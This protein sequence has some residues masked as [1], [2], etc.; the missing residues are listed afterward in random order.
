MNNPSPTLPEPIR[1][2]RVK[3][4]RI[5]WEASDLDLAEITAQRA[6][7]LAP[8]IATG[9]WFLNPQYTVSSAAPSPEFFRTVLN[10][11]ASW[12]RTCREVQ[13]TSGQR[14]LARQVINKGRLAATLT[15]D[16]VAGLDIPSHLSSRS[17]LVADLPDE[18]RRVAIEAGQIAK[19]LAYSGILFIDGNPVPPRTWQVMHEGLSTAH[20]RANDGAGSPDAVPTSRYLSNLPGAS[21]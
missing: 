8:Q 21:R 10:L 16:P 20:S 7:T 6:A 13:G 15:I 18:Q 4:H 12:L 3:R 17:V 14:H 11:R 5:D 2:V 1:P 19:M 9:L